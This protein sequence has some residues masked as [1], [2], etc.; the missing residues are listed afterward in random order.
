MENSADFTRLQ[1]LS[2]QT[3][4]LS[5]KTKD[6]HFVSRQGMCGLL[7]GLQLLVRVGVCQ[8]PTFWVLL[9]ARWKVSLWGTLNTFFSKPNAWH[10]SV[11]TGKKAVV[12]VRKISQGTTASLQLERG[13][14]FKRALSLWISQGLIL[15]SKA[16]G[17][18]TPFSHSLLRPVRGTWQRSKLT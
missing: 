10:S 4:L 14:Q 17:R 12:F 5:V 9:E 16:A 11:L 8:L 13:C 7:L 3:T 1:R 2:R 18:S 6:I 15:S